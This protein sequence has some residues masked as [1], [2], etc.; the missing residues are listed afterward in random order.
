MV[1]GHRHDGKVIGTLL[2]F[3]FEEGSARVELGYV[4]GRVY[5]GQG[6]MT[7]AVEAICAHVFSALGM[8]RIE[9]EVNPV[10]TASDALLRKVGFTLEGTLRKRWVAKGE[11]YDTNV[12]GYLAEEW[13]ALRR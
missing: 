10:N 5:W 4:L 13:Q 8:R 3:R 6:L 7:E 9:A 1:L 12:Y 11:A 2:L